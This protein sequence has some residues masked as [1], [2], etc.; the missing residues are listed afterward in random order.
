M[1]DSRTA[2]GFCRLCGRV[3]RG[4]FEERPDHACQR[5]NEESVDRVIAPFVVIE[6]KQDRGEIAAAER[7][8]LAFH[9]R[10]DDVRWISL[11]RAARS[12]WPGIDSERDNR[13][14]ALRIKQWID[15][16]RPHEMAL[17]RRLLR[18]A[19]VIELLLRGT[20]DEPAQVEGPLL[21]ADEFLRG[22]H[23]SPQATVGDGQRNA[24]SV[25][26]ASPKALPEKEREKEVIHDDDGAGVTHDA[27]DGVSLPALPAGIWKPGLS[28]RAIRS[29][30]A[31]W[32][33]QHREA[34]NRAGFASDV[35][36]AAALATRRCE[37]TKATAYFRRVLIKGPDQQYLDEARELIGE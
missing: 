20:Q 29:L 35:F 23:G 4:E 9:Q 15:E 5:C 36:F 12:R 21:A 27:K 6:K 18:V 24:K 10:E 33:E 13:I 7:G 3:L 25:T 11:R 37:R 16:E 1:T 2:D 30:I 31:D 34:V 17:Q 22:T 14:I 26:A 19:T 32:W 8:R 28:S